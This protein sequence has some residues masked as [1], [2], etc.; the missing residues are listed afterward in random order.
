MSDLDCS[1]ALQPVAAR[2]EF[3]DMAFTADDDAHVFD[4]IRNRDPDAPFAYIV[5]PNVDHIVRLQRNRSDLWPAYR[6][7]WMT[8]C[9]SRI[10]ARLA[11]R[12]G[13]PL[14]VLPGSDLT[15]RMIEKVIGR[16]DRIAILGGGADGVAALADRYG[17]RAVAHYEPPMRF[18]DDPAAVECA[19]RFAI[20]ARAR[21]HFFALGSPQQ[22]MLAYRIAR[23]GGATGIG[24]CVGASLDFLTGAQNRAP[25]SMQHLSMEWLYRLGSDPRRLWRRY[26]VDGP[27]IFG[28]ARD[29]RRAHPAVAHRP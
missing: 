3:I 26:L 17:L 25:E 9:D 7:A 15:I 23:M 13:L 11:R 10:L 8:L 16:D 2:V 5:T 6:A 20:D 19:A 27:E 28:I 29:W 24:F 21:Y 18:I 1:P 22:E 12:S 4:V 14:P